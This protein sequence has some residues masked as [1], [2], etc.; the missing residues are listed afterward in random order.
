M[1]RRMD[2]LIRSA[3]IKKEGLFLLP[4]FLPFYL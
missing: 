2:A 4:Y 1:E 3:R